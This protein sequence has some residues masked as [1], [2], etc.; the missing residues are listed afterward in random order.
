MRSKE[1][2]FFFVSFKLK[3]LIIFINEKKNKNNSVIELCFP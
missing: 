1:K 2:K 3:N